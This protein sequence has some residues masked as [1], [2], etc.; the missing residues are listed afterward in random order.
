MRDLLNKL[1]HV[2]DSGE[3]VLEVLVC[4]SGAFVLLASDAAIGLM[5]ELVE[6]RQKWMRVVRSCLPAVTV[7]LVV[8]AASVAPSS[9][10]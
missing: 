6:K 5:I 3:R 9:S 1:S 4:I 7:G 2:S 10:S 8:T